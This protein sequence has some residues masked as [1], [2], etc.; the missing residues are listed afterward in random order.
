MP[1][2]LF[3]ICLVPL[4]TPLVA[5]KELFVP[6]SDVSFTITSE[7]ADN[8]AGD[9][10]V[11]RYQI[12]NISNHPLYVPRGFQATACL[13]KGGAPHIRGWFEDRTGRHFT[14]GYGVSC[15]GTPG[16]PP[17][18]IIQRMNGAAVLLGPGEN[19]KGQLQLNPAMFRLPP[20]AYRIKAI[21]TGW[22]SDK[23]TDA[24]RAE[25]EQMGNPFLEG[26]TPASTVVS[27]H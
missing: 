9:Q 22:Q 5:Q 23:F 25:L 6:V 8:S 12:T 13:E 15:A 18:T 17:P 11:V 4:A 3:A 24:E 19:L 14:P 2:L 21:L 26:E 16:A 20:G 1:R 10:I 7:K 27:L